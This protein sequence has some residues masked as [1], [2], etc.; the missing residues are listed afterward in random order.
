MAVIEPLLPAALDRRR[1]WLAHRM[2][3]EGLAWRFR[4][5]SPWRDLP[6]R[7]GPWNTVFKRFD[8]WAKDGTWQKILTVVQ[9]H[10][11]EL[12]DVDWVASIDSTIIRVHQAR[13]EHP[14]HGGLHRMTRFSRPSPAIMRSGSPGA[15]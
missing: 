8:R 13:R 14:P 12:G 15:V 4:T 7:F 9:A 11:D 2:V 5:G 6:E 1:P 10:A 3:V